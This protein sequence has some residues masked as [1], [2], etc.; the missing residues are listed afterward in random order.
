MLKRTAIDQFCENMIGF[1]GR[2]ARFYLRLGNDSLYSM[3]ND[4]QMLEWD[5]EVAGA[6]KS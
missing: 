1:H 3:F 2:S 4:Q 6:Q 5:L